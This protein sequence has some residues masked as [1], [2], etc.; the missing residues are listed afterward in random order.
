MELG[1]DREAPGTVRTET[2]S[3]SLESGFSEAI[4]R[5]GKSP[6]S[7][8]GPR[9]WEL[10]GLER[11]IASLKVPEAWPFVPEVLFSNALALSN[12]SRNKRV[13]VLYRDLRLLELKIKNFSSVSCR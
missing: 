12:H 7:F 5:I 3:S 8:S 2:G 1:A 6:C 10:G 11:L 9:P 4:K 13:G